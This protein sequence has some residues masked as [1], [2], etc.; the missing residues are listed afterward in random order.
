MKFRVRFVVFVF[1]AALVAGLVHA[2]DAVIYPPIKLRGYGTLSGTFTTDASGGSVL[3]IVCEDE[4]KAKLVHAK[5]LS[6]LEVLPGVVRTETPSGPHGN[7]SAYQTPNG[8]LEAVHVGSAVYVFAGRTLEDVDK[9]QMKQIMSLGAVNSDFAPRVDVPMYLDRFDKFGL[10]FY[11]GPFVVPEGTKQL[12]DYDPTQ[13]FDFAKQTHVG[14]QF[15]HTPLSVDNAEGITNMPWTLWAVKAA[16][17]YGLPVGINDGLEHVTW[18]YN[19]WPEQIVGYQPGFLGGWYGSMNFS[20]EISSWNGLEAKDHEMGELQ[21]SLR[22]LSAYKNITSWLEPHEEMSHGVADLLLEYGPVAD[23]GYRAFL[24]EKYHDLATVARRWY[25]DPKAINSWSEIKAPELA[26]FLGDPP[27]TSDVSPIYSRVGPGPAAV[28]LAGP[29]KISYDQPFGP[30][31]GATTLDDSSWPTVQAPNDAIVRFLPRKPAVYRRHINLSPD[32]RAEMRKIWL[33]CW[34][35]NDTRDVIND[36]NKGVQIYVNGTLLPETPLKITSDHWVA[37]DA[38][39][40]LH[41]GDNLIAITLPN[42]LFNYR[43][44]LSPHEPVLYP[45][46]GPQQNARWVDFYDWNVWFRGNAVRRGSQMIRQVDADSGIMLMAPHSYQES[47]SDVAK[48]Y[49]GDFHDTG[50]MAGSWQ[51]DP[52]ALAQGMG[53]PVSDEPGGPAHSGLEEKAFFGRWLTE[54]A[55]AIDYFQHEGDILWYPDRKKVFEDHLPIYSSAGKYHTPATGVAALYSMRND[56]LL[57]FPW[58]GGQGYGSTNALHLGSGQSK[59]NVR[60]PLRGDFDADSLMEASFARGDAARYA[61]IID[62]NTSI[63]D[64]P[65]LAQIEKYVR[66]GGTFVTY[67][68]TGRHTSLVPDSWPIEKLTGYHV[69]KLTQDTPWQTGAITWGKGQPIFSGD[70]IAQPKADGMSMQRAKIREFNIGEEDGRQDLA[71]WK[72]GSVAIGMRHLG[73]GQIIE[74]GCRFTSWGLPDRIDRDIWGYLKRSYNRLTE[75]GFSTDPNASLWTP[76]LVATGKLFG[77]ILDWRGVARVPGQLTPQSEDGLLRHYISNNGLYDVWNVWNQNGTRDLDTTLHLT[78]PQPAFAIN[79]L[80]GSR[81]TLSGPDLP[82]H[83][84]AYETAIYLTPRAEVADASQQW[85]ELQRRWWQG[86]ADA[87]APFP[88]VDHKLTRD[89]TR[90]WAFSPITRQMGRV[91]YD[92]TPS[93]FK[94]LASNT[95]DMSPYFSSGFDDSKWAKMDFGI[96]TIPDYPDVHTGLFRKSFTV[97]ESWDHGRVSIWIRAWDGDTFLGHGKVYLDGKLLRDCGTGGVEGDEAGG[98]L[99]PGSTHLLAVEVTRLDGA[100]GPTGQAGL[101]GSRGPAWIAYH[102]EPAA[103]QDLAGPWETATDGLRYAATST[104]PGTGQ[105]SNRRTVKIDADQSSR[106]VV[107]HALAGSGAVRGIII[108]GRFVARHHHNIG[109]EVNLNITPWV[110]FGQENTFVMMGSDNVEVKEVSLEFHTKGTYP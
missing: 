109:P 39:Q 33:Y 72:D 56:G 105:F 8:F 97:P 62:T 35:L 5:F 103:R 88:A 3:K 36:P 14:M 43:A 58:Y 21:A 73:K 86:T 57:N 67:V 70:W 37:L 101:I 89:L 45:N 63:I 28:D 54:G 110:K 50:S 42:G 24:K 4:A 66:D 34:D 22:Q 76:E 69:T 71:Y 49:G 29:W 25:G 7:T 53:L 9:A 18:A 10:R 92:G 87:G 78:V 108:N 99:K 104:L 38:T 47:I 55:N 11:Y 19:R 79:L 98:A 83:L 102:P 12:T 107:F 61:V 84:T 51:D 60:A 59:W 74:V 48:A 80:D 96:F 26:S 20:E 23:V 13:D 1:V 64:P 94:S 91:P 77:Q 30:E 41:D 106:T 52:A 27:T 90:N 81:T 85:F 75:Y 6:D 2:A 82:I 44:Y 68:Q 46:L 31:A 17:K 95:R 15:W 16:N 65:L 40:A 32:W 100:L 93:L